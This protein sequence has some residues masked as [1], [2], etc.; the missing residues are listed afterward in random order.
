MDFGFKFQALW[1]NNLFPVCYLRGSPCLQLT[2]V[3]DL[4]THNSYLGCKF[5]I[6]YSWFHKTVLSVYTL[7][8]VATLF[9]AQTKQCLSE[10][11]KGTLFMKYPASEK[12]NFIYLRILL[13]VS[14]SPCLQA[15]KNSSS[16]IL[17]SYK[18]SWGNGALSKY[19][20]S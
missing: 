19:L 4:N 11:R 8:M 16:L 17:N 12:K 6:S 9:R 7:I 20:H 18:L 15:S 14:V 5:T 10:R 3:P 13:N 2:S 1:F